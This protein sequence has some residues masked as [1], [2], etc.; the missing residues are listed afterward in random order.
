MAI[1]KRTQD[2]KRMVPNHMRQK[3]ELAFTCQQFADLSK[4]QYEVQRDEL[5]AELNAEGFEIAIGEAIHCDQGK[6]SITETNSYT[7]DKD[8][9]IDMVKSG[10][11]TLETLIHMANIPVTP[12]K[13]ALSESD[14][15]DIVSVSQTPSM[16]L[17]ADASFKEKVAENFVQIFSVEPKAEKA[18][19]KPKA[20]KPEKVVKPKAEK[21]KA[22]K[23]EKSAEEELAEILGV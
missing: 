4:K 15:K 7:V 20:D 14:Y 6:I 2:D 22:V 1:K 16:R 5:M 17:T 3:A 12:L 11:M 19:E 8:K 18:V 9:L 21:P 23:K 13:T 10:K